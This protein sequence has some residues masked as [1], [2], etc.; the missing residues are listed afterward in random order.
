MLLLGVVSQDKIGLS[1]RRYVFFLKYEVIDSLDVLAVLR[2]LN[3]LKISK[4]RAP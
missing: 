2:G 4:L 3:L 1:F